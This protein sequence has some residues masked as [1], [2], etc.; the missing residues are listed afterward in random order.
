MS[1]AK[2]MQI[3]YRMADWSRQDYYADSKAESVFS[4]LVG[5]F[6]FVF[7]V[8]SYDQC[9]GLSLMLSRRR[10]SIALDEG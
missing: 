5:R 7:C 8:S 6:A 4:A 10:S 3:Q 1:A 2:R 9:A